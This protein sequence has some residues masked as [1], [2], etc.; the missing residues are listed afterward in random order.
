MHT[1][2]KHTYAFIAVY[3]YRYRDSDD[4]FVHGLIFYGLYTK[5]DVCQ[6][7]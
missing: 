3:H 6:T 4:V 2:H 5:A 1:G 7:Q